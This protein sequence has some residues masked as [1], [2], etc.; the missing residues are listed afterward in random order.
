MSARDAAIDELV[1][2]LGVER[3]DAGAIVDRIVTAAAV[4]AGARTAEALVEP[5][6][7]AVRKHADGVTA[8]LGRA[9]R[10]LMGGERG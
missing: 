5:L 9:H 2:V 8:L 10:E 4:E 6:S 1:R 3:G 7:I